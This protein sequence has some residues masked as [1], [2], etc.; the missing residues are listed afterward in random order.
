MF[1]IQWKDI[2]VKEGQNIG[3]SSYYWRQH[4]V[5][6]TAPTL[7]YHEREPLS[8]QGQHKIPRTSKSSNDSNPHQMMTIENKP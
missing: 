5:S 7:K 1:L 2:Y 4:L 6:G 3:V 8:I